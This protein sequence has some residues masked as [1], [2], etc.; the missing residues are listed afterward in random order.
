ML[1][2]KIVNTKLRGAKRVTKMVISSLL[3]FYVV[4][5]SGLI[6]IEWFDLFYHRRSEMRNFIKPIIQYVVIIIGVRH[7]MRCLARVYG[8]D[9]ESVLMAI[10]ILKVLV[11]V[12]IE[13]ILFVRKY[14]E[15]M[16]KRVGIF[17]LYM[18]IMPIISIGIIT[19]GN[20]YLIN[21]RLNN[22]Y[23]ATINN[24][25]LTLTS[26]I[27]ILI[28][29]EIYRYRKSKRRNL[30]ILPF[31]M[32]LIIQLGA[33]YFFE[34]VFISQI[35][36][37]NINYY[38]IVYGLSAVVF[39]CICVIYK[40]SLKD[41][42]Y[43]RL[44]KERQSL[45]KRQNDYLKAENEGLGILRKL[46]HDFKKHAIIIKGLSQTNRREELE[47]YIDNLVGQM[48]PATK[49]V[50]GDNI[51]VS[52]Q[53]THM[54]ARCE[55][56][57]IDF[58]YR[59]GY[60]QILIEPFDLNVVIGNILDNAYEASLNLRDTTTRKIRLSIREE[61][62]MIIISCQ[63]PYAGSIERDG[64]RIVSSKSNKVKHGL[65]IANIK[66]VA[67]KYAGKVDIESSEQVFT[68]YVMLQNILSN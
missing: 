20:N 36:E 64:K 45:Y 37:A 15:G 38:L 44:E 17:L 27:L 24:F 34:K 62:G 58:K 23:I 26:Y 7:L 1:C 43:K 28:I 61:R 11:D 6:L 63:N 32:I 8:H 25:T 47:Q 40:N 57:K 68:I 19:W 49:I 21:S 30:H 59:L 56:E 52:F 60:H 39:T 54:A 67:E 18:L 10:D 5:I 12:F 46:E 4:L 51:V 42:E 41:Q 48:L 9:S 14:Q 31:M 13:W 65:G 66:E 3:E 29:G 33:H 55:A 53:L 50:E 22:N 16:L 35:T 2:S